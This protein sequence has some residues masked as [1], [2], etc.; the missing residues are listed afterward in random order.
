V[1]VG[2]LGKVWDSCGEGLKILTQGANENAR[3]DLA[4]CVRYQ[5]G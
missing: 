3:V 2:I 1:V 4:N 5:A